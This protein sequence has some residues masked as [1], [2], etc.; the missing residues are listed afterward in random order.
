MAVDDMKFR[1]IQPD[2]HKQSAAKHY[3]KAHGKN[4]MGAV[5]VPMSPVKARP[6]FRNGDLVDCFL[7]DRVGVI[8]VRK[9][10]CPAA[11]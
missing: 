2:F 9:N 5:W 8:A 10:E 4:S 1:H 11:T 3:P 7:D 6:A